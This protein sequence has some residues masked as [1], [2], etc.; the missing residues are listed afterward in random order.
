[1][2]LVYAARFPQKVRKLVLAGAPVDVKAASSQLSSLAEGTPLGIF[3]ELVRLGD[4]LV[5]G[6]KLMR[7]W[8]PDSVNSESIRRLL[9]TKAGS[10]AAAQIDLEA[11]FRDWYSWAIDLPG[12][13]FLEVVERLYKGNELANGKFVALGRQVDLARLHT[14]I[15]MLAARD[16]ELIAA[17]QLFAVAA[18]V[19]TPPHNLRKATAPCRHVGLFMGERT[20]GEIWPNIA[21]WIREPQVSISAPVDAPAA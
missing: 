1:M 20:L 18:L 4:G 14:P 21:Q 8:G 11:R 16:D 19:G 10:D 13:F 2:A 9:Q 12:T 3:R 7:F 17:Q 5:L 15:F 6:H